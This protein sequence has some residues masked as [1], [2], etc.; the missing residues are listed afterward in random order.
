MRA[1][2]SIGL[3]GAF[4]AA[5]AA[6]L[7]MGNST[8]P[9]PPFAAC[10]AFRHINPERLPR[11][12]NDD[13]NDA[14]LASMLDD[15]LSHPP[16]PPWPDQDFDA[17]IVISTDDGY[18]LELMRREVVA[19][20]RQGVWQVSGRS[21]SMKQGTDRWSEWRRKP[22]S[23]GNSERLSEILTDECLW[24]AP[25][26]IDQLIPLRNGA[27]AAS[28][29]SPSNTYDVQGPDRRWNGHHSFWTL[30][31][32]GRLRSILVSEA[33]GL[34]EWTNEDVPEQGDIRAQEICNWG[35]SDSRQDICR[36]STATQ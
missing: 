34:P 26:F 36:P 2:I 4:L 16:V 21:R 11:H 7:P 32:P 17:Q 19:R 3:S 9:P 31:P 6:P 1:L 35:P 23:P 25:R 20:R 29:D 14:L 15:W 28:F 8:K 30:G 33:F 27:Y 18:T 12:L 24:N 5:V 22:V 10:P 13:P